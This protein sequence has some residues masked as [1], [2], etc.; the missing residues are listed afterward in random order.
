MTNYIEM[1]P[2]KIQNKIYK[3]LAKE[4]YEEVLKEYNDQT[5][6]IGDDWVWF[7][8]FPEGDPV[9]VKIKGEPP[10]T[11]NFNPRRNL[12]SLKD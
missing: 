11:H 3:M 6:I 9:L 12:K 10:L 8:I 4:L 5:C 1:L 7:D 2:S